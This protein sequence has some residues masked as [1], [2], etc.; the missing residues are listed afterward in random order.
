M[1]FILRLTR[2]A[3]W[4]LAA[5]IL[6]NNVGELFCTGFAADHLWIRSAALVPG[7]RW[8]ATA[9]AVALIVPERWLR[10]RPILSAA[11]AA[12]AAA[13]AGF[14][15]LD[16]AWFYGMLAEGAIR[17][18][19]VVPF[20]AMIA[21]VLALSAVRIW[22]APRAAAGNSAPT[23]EVKPARFAFLRWAC[24]EG[25][26]LAVSGAAVMLGFI[27]T[28]GPTDYSVRADCAVV[29]G[30]KA[31]RDGRPSLALYDRTMEGVA[32]YRR[33]LVKKLVMSGA[34]DN[35][36]GGVSEPA[37]M[38]RVAVEAGVP[39][40]DI[41]I[42]EHGDDSWATVCNTRK[43]AAEHGWGRV[44]L[45]SHY[46]HLP[47]LRLAADRAGLDARTVPCRQTRRLAKEPYGIARE[48]AGL[49]YYYFFHLP[50]AGGRE[51]R[52]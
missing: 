39:A 43:L 25:A 18:R 24:V 28:Y 44:L 2:A 13:F 17:T 10:P 5:F 3:G 50:G 21:F 30:A 33:G 1:A 9:L 26:I 47:R 32:L 38:R 42:D 34:I 4:W 40:E 35:G 19:A 12:V 20:S 8:L 23:P 52:G 7:W 14:A 49:G 45:V 48:M 15:A 22:R 6:A 37:V 31:H 51:L 16:A 27:L 41:I 36:A 46:Y 29:L 11:A